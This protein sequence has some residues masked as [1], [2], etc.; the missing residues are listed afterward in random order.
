MFRSIVDYLRLC[1]AY[2]RININAQ[3]EYRGAFY[4]QV[5][6]MF[7]NDGAWVVFWLL[8]FTKFQVLHGWSLKDVTSLWA[9]TTAGFGLAYGFMGNAH[10]KLA[11]AIAQA[12]TPPGPRFCAPYCRTCYWQY[13]PRVGR[14]GVRQYLFW[15]CKTE[16][17]AGVVRRI[18]DCRRGR[19]CRIWR[20]DRSRVYVG[21]ASTLS[22]QWRD[23]SIT[24]ATYPPTL[25]EGKKFL[26]F[27][28][29]PA[30]FISYLPVE[31]LRSMSIVDLLIAIA[32]A[33]VSWP[34]V[35]RSTSAF[36]ATNPAPHSM[37][38]LGSCG[39]DPQSP[40]Y[41]AL[42]GRNN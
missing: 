36:A 8:F 27:T 25:F 41:C 20:H 4:S 37:P 12:H 31:S 21:N 23:I 3:L 17:S 11:P 34:P 26:L 38:E 2:L 40:N 42:T 10:R 16:C 5:A 30:G 15:F 14:R 9:T 13:R 39:T 35:W 29:I 33:V 32:G 19:V 1:A 18:V 22:D 28:V 6:A 24:F 7:I